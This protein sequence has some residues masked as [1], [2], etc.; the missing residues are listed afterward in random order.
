M[1]DTEGRPL[2]STQ[3][4]K[5]TPQR[6]DSNTGCFGCL[7]SIGKAFFW[8]LVICFIITKCNG[9]KG[10]NKV[11]ESQSPVQREEVAEESN[12]T[13]DDANVP[14]EEKELTLSEKASSIEKA[15]FHKFYTDLGTV[16][17]HQFKE[18]ADLLENAVELMER[19]AEGEFQFLDYQ[20]K[21][22]S[23]NYYYITADIDAKYYYVGDT[24][25]N[26]PDGFGMIFSFSK[27][28]G[29]YDLIDQFMIHY[30]GEF[31]EGAFHGFGAQFSADEYD[32]TG[33]IYELNQTGAVSSEEIGGDL[34]MYLFNHVSYEGHFKDGRRN[35]KGNQ[36]DILPLTLQYVN[37]PI[38]GYRYYYA[39]PD[40]IKGNYKND[41]LV[42]DATI[43]EHNHLRFEGK[44]TDGIGTGKGTWYYSN[45]QICYEGEFKKE[46]A[47]GK[48]KYYSENGELLYSGEWK[49]G[50]YAH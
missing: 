25:D 49:N 15:Y 6:N 17:I 1:S 50:D 35:G 30:I 16:E 13:N 8:I 2:I 40:V 3:D 20:I 42:G 27:G 41:T 39:Y 26:R 32:L 43:Y 46:K 24:K 36:F 48:G 33:T 18:R 31:K 19:A 21:I 11:T 12:E 5:A 7:W 29:T 23:T 10:D 47:N 45:G 34:V 28:N 44:L 14:G 38:D 37:E 4:N 9:D 22:L